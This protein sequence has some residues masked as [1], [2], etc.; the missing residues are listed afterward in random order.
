LRFTTEKK[1]TKTKLRM[2]LED[3]SDIKSLNGL[4]THSPDA[5]KY[6]IQKTYDVGWPA[7]QKEHQQTYMK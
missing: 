3:L 6:K 5:D 1:N 4:I 2:K 7:K